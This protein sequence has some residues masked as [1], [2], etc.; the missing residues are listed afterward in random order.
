MNTVLLAVCCILI[1]I[2][3]VSITAAIVYQVRLGTC[4]TARN[5]WCYTDW[6]CL[7]SNVNGDG[8]PYV[9]DS[10]STIISRCTPMFDDINASDPAAGTARVNRLNAAGCRNTGYIGDDPQWSH[11]TPRI[12]NPT[13]G[14]TDPERCLGAISST[15][16]ELCPPY[17]IGDIDWTTST[18]CIP[19]KGYQGTN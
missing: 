4:R 15:G 7:T 13:T 14:E 17:K 1:V 11:C 9:V 16:V 8:E 10:V 3:I 18:G 12:I 2:F 5:P 19:A 6:K